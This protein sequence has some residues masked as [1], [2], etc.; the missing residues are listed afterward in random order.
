MDKPLNGYVD[1]AF[2]NETALIQRSGRGNG[3]IVRNIDT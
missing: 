1:L 3:L 2:S